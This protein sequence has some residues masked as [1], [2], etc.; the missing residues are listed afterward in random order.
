[1]EQ[2]FRQQEG[3]DG[4]DVLVQQNSM[5]DD[6]RS[7][8]ALS[9]G[10]T[11]LQTTNL[12]ETHDLKL[13]INA[14]TIFLAAES[15]PPIPLLVP[16]VSQQREL[17]LTA[18]ITGVSFLLCALHFAWYSVLENTLEAE[19][20]AL[21]EDK[22][23]IDKLQKSL[24]NERKKLK[25]LQEELT[26]VADGSVD[27]EA[28]LRTAKERPVRLLRA[29]ARGLPEQTILESICSEGDNLVVQGVSLSPRGPNSL[30]R[31]I[32]SEAKN[33]GW[34]ANSPTKKD[35]DLFTSG[36]PWSFGLLLEDQGVG[37]L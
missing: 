12:S 17:Q 23:T 9:D 30:A 20:A 34:K 1:M 7:Q 37:A 22:K 5:E 16:A 3:G 10:P 2:W 6:G 29:L 19:V 35:L 18:A 31:A 21:R 28:I 26:V 32:E 11:P 36:G 14:W 24:A 4:V 15:D 33:L 13:W 27:T 8:E 25:S